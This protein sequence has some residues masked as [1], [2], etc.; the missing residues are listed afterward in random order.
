MTSPM[1]KIMMI[2]VAMTAL[3]ACSK[4]NDSRPARANGN[5]GVSGGGSSS[6]CTTAGQATGRVYDNGVSGTSFEQR[7]KGLLSASVDPQYFGTIS[8]NGNDAQTGV[9]IEGRLR[10]D[11]NGNIL[12]DQ[13]NLKLIVT[14]SYVGQKDS[15]GATIQAYPIQFS[16]ASSG[17]MNL[18]TKTFTVLFK[19]SYGE[20]TVT[21]TVNGSVVSGSISY[22]N[23]VSY[24]NSTPASGSLGAYQ[25]ATCG[26]IH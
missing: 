5:V 18:S 11:S 23:Y 12:L 6:T 17:N 21:G 1:K 2:L 15:N 22:N 19:D 24:D 13:T 20:V 25:I 9:T 4:S 8:G 10:Y 14:D 3:V 16:T 26:L 7:V